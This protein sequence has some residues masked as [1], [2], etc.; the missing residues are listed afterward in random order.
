MLLMKWC[1]KKEDINDVG[2]TGEKTQSDVL[3]EAGMKSSAQAGGWP[4][5]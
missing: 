4:Y 1:I 3:E 5:Q 2:E